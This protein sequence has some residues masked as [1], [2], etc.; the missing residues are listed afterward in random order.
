[1]NDTAHEERFGVSSLELFFDLVFVFAI[2]QVTALIAADP[3]AT[4]ML[5]GVLLL[6]LVW[7]SWVAYAWI[8]TTVRVDLGLPA[9]VFGAAM[10]AMLVVAT[11]L[12]QWFTGSRIAW[13]AV[14][15][16]VTVRAMHLGLFLVLGRGTP[17]IAGA[18]ARLAV[19]VGLGAVLLLI[20]TGVGGTAQLV[21]VALAVTADFAG[22]LLGRGRGWVVHVEH[23]AERH[24][25]IVI[26]ALGESLIAL[27]LAASDT[28]MSGGVLLT[29][30]A[31][32]ALSAAIWLLYFARETA[33]L[34]HAL[35]SAT[36]AARGRAARDLCSYLHFPI[37]LGIVLV[38]LALK[39]GVVAIDVGGL[40]A[41]LHGVGAIAL[42]LGVPLVLGALV[43]MRARER[44]GI[45]S[46]LMLALVG[47]ALIGLGA[48]QV[49][50]L[51]VIL[52]QTVL[53]AAATL[54]RADGIL[55]G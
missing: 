3:T 48:A 15:T 7:W 14:I 52:A 13:I 18:T 12:P 11:T 29:L 40:G 10:G 38:A 47:A 27:G 51:A 49:P 45:P 17:G 30:A 36:G 32:F 9:L 24:G 42:G 20:G 2:T 4:G 44:S 46:P 21:L 1:M 23:F 55:R 22:A 43:A 53:V 6:A 8:G 26:I 35:H 33:P 5:R 54:R 16:Y 31:G 50:L 37:V 41:T 34:E 39:K 19:G 28:A 25:L